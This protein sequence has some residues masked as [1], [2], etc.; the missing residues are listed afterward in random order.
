VKQIVLFTLAVAASWVVLGVGPVKADQ[1]R[2]VREQAEVIVDG[3][4]W[5][6]QGSRHTADSGVAT[7]TPI[8]GAVSPQKAAHASDQGA[9]PFSQRHFFIPAKLLR[10]LEFVWRHLWILGF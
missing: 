7:D 8:G 10:F 6:P 4:P 2:W 5:E 1:Q 9:S 3:D